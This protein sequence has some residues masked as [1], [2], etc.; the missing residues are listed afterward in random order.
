VAQA[1]GVGL[2]SEPVDARVVVDADPNWLERLVLNLVDNAIKFTPAGG[3][4]R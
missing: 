3:I 2:R 1:K 4:S